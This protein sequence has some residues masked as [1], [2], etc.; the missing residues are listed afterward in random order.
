MKD[1]SLFIIAK[2]EGDKL[3]A[4]IES[5]KNLCSEVIVCDSGSTD[6]TAKVAEEM[7]AKVVQHD[8]VG[9]AD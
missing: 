8:F 9:F 1:I 4:C 2:N 3:K 6:D 5:G 7:G